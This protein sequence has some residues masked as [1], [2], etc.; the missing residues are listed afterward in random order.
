LSSKQYENIAFLASDSIVKIDCRQWEVESQKDQIMIFHLLPLRHLTKKNVDGCVN[1]DKKEVWSLFTAQD[2]YVEYYQKDGFS[3][4]VLYQSGAFNYRKFSREETTLI[5][6]PKIYLTE[7]LDT[8][9]SVLHTSLESDYQRD[10][11]LN[12]CLMDSGGFVVKRWFETI[13][14]FTCAFISMKSVLSENKSHLPSVGKFKSYTLLAVCEN[15]ALLPLILNIDGTNNT[16]AV[17]HSLPPLYYGS[18]VTGKV[19]AKVV[20]DLKSKGV[21]HGKII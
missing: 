6:A 18:S 15:A 20:A 13:K 21:I 12:C 5:Q 4:G 3:S 7:T 17:E 14:P 9:L 8:V 16:L 2:H 11:I 10:A 19:R 1:I